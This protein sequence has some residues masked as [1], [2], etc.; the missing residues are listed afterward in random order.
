[1][2]RKRVLPVVAEGNIFGAKFMKGVL[3][4]G[5]RLAHYL[6]VARRDSGRRV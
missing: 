4:R 6:Y 5:R 3:R 1:M 2:G